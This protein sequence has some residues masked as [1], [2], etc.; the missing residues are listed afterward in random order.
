M[1]SL[2]YALCCMASLGL[3]WVIRVIIT[4]AIIN[5]FKNEDI[6]NK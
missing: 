5:A 2:C 1:D 3:V 6:K 4:V